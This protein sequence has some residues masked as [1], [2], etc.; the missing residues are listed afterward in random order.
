MGIAIGLQVWAS[1]VAWP[2]LMAAG[3]AIDGLGFESLW[4][5][6][7]F[8]P[9]LGPETVVGRVDGPIFE[10]W[11]VLA[12][13]ATVT[14]R[15]RLGCLVSGAAYRNPG[16]L[17]RMATALDHASGG[18]AVLGIGAGWHEREHR[19]YGFPYPGVGERLDRLEEAAAICRGLLDG[20]RVSL[21]GRWYAAQDAVNDPPPIQPRLPLVIG[22][23]G[24]KRTLRIVA[25]FADWWNADGNDPAEF[26]RLGGVLDDHCVAVGRDP[27]SIRRTIGQQP[28]L[29]RRT[30]RLAQRDLAAI[31]ARHGM[32]ADVARDTA[33][34]NPYAGPVSAI[35]DRLAAMAEVGASLAVFDWMAPFDRQTLEGLAGIAETLAVG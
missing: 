2:D 15:V 28:P 34:T 20:E 24:E 17:V 3:R 35:T 9:A 29:V 14:S 1:H 7:H 8:V 16:V 32:P 6:D 4:S 11:S 10:G 5:N 19:M 33:A 25:R 31:L 26:A 21:A 13:W 12:G 30:T 22:G 27:A 23:S 18:R